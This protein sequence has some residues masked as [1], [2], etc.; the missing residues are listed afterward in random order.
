M[1]RRVLDQGR[2][3]GYNASM[4]TQTIEIDDDTATALKQRARQRGLTVPELV[5]E[6]V[7]LEAGA[8]DADAADIAE[9]DRRWNAFEAQGSVAANDDVV[10]WL[11][12]WGTP[13][14][15]SWRKR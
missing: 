7:T 2:A 9:L 11:Q 10:R 1:S 8:V 13:A 4:K 15:R 14:F 3:F 5:A 6:L 12:T